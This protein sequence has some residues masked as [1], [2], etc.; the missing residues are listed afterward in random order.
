MSRI[1]G[2]R[3]GGPVVRNKKFITKVT[4]LQFGAGDP[5]TRISR[6]KQAGGEVHLQFEDV[7]S[8]SSRCE[9]EVGFPEGLVQSSVL[10]SP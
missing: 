1:S 9:R 10:I 4:G 2:R 5:F 8:G 3:R 7:Q 6:Q